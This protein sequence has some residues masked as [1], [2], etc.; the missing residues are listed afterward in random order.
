MSKRTSLE[1][2]I[3]P[4]RFAGIFP[5]QFVTEAGG[6]SRGGEGRRSA[7]GH[8]LL[9]RWSHRL[10]PRWFSWAA[11]NPT[12]R[13]APP[14]WCAIY[15]T[16]CQARRS[17]H[18]EDHGFRIRPVP[19]RAPPLWYQSA[20]KFRRDAWFAN[21]FIR[22]GLAVPAPSDF[23]H[24]TLRTYLGFLRAYLAHRREMAEMCNPV[25]SASKVTVSATGDCA[26]WT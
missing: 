15:L 1:E 25:G 20:H 2:G 14:R 5:E 23:L 22:Q 10:R 16:S 18:H 4:H 3:K 9:S 21:I 13:S 11:S 7:Y 6:H 26:D 12:R 19:H 17:N 24:S 8:P